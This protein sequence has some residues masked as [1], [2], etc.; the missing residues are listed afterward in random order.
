MSK[1]RKEDTQIYKYAGF[2]VYD[3]LKKN[4]LYLDNDILNLSSEQVLSLKGINY[5]IYKRFKEYIIKHCNKNNIEYPKYISEIKAIKS[6]DNNYTYVLYI[7]IPDDIRNYI[8]YNNAEFLRKQ[9]IDTIQK[10]INTDIKHFLSLKG[11]GGKRFKEIIEDRCKYLNDGSTYQSIM[12]NL[13]NE[14]IN[15]RNDEIYL[16]ET[17][18]KLKNEIRVVFHTYNNKLYANEYELNL[19]SKLL[20]SRE[21]D[22]L[23][24]RY[25]K[26]N[27]LE[28]T[29]I[30]FNVTRERIRSIQKNAEEKIAA[31]YKEYMISRLHPELNLD[32]NKI[33]DNASL[34][35]YLEEE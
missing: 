2:T 5:A 35:F 1:Y 20:S 4:K 30:P 12:N 18:E 33:K 27:T 24:S 13:K 23:K 34:L 3:L 10:F 16:K 25:I 31:Y 28:K 8:K 9:G 26:G 7:P 32:L 11:I 6:C 19:S 21:Q 17:T 14:E 22:I 15:K 29:A